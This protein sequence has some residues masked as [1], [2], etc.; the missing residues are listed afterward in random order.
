MSV[1]YASSPTLS[2]NI[3]VGSAGNQTIGFDDFWSPLP[4]SDRRGSVVI[5]ARAAPARGFG[6]SSFRVAA[7]RHLLSSR[8]ATVHGPRRRGS[9]HDNLTK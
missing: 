6:P 9:S 7:R 5:A 4:P 3:T 8:V 1:D 2:G